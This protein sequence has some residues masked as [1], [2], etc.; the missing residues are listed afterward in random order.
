MI[1]L[2]CPP[3]HLGGYGSFDFLK[4]S[5]RISWQLES[6][7]TEDRMGSI[8][9]GAAAARL[10]IIVISVLQLGGDI[11]SKAAR[12]PNPRRVLLI[13]NAQRQNEGRNVL[14]IIGFRKGIAREQVRRVVENVTAAGDYAVDVPA[15]MRQERRAI[16]DCSRRG[17]LVGKCGGE[18]KT[19]SGG[20]GCID[21]KN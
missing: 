12:Q 17:G 21:R 14:A 19:P 3:R 1:D 4:H 5:L 13:L 15:I 18:V 9:V 20:E 7:R 10:I 6:N 8:I 2:D 16:V 11:L